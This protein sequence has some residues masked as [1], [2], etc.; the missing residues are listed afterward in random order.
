MKFSYD[1]ALI[2]CCSIVVGSVVQIIVEK[3]FGMI[4]SLL[5]G[6]VT[7]VLAHWVLLRNGKNRYSLGGLTIMQAQKPETPLLRKFIMLTFIAS[8]GF[9]FIVVLLVRCLV[10]SR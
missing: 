7:V 4:T 9:A 6:V 1:T 2:T 3:Y 10:P 5:C 8:L